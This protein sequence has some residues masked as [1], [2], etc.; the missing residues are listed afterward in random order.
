MA[1]ERYKCTVSFTA[2]N[3]RH[4]PWHIHVDVKV[5]DVLAELIQICTSPSPPNPFAVDFDYFDA[6]HLPERALASGA[7]AAFLQRIVASAPHSYNKKGK[8]AH[9]M[10]VPISENSEGSQIHETI[11]FKH[12]C[13]HSD[14]KLYHA[15]IP[16]HVGTVYWLYFL[17]I[18]MPIHLLIYIL[19]SVQSDLLKISQCHFNAVSEL[20]LEGAIQPVSPETQPPQHKET[21][22]PLRSQQTSGQMSSET[23]QQHH[24]NTSDQ[25]KF[26]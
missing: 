16:M 15:H 2:F 19:H 5:W 6:L 17:S 12:G 14:S 3:L 24:C 21:V 8:I 10:C 20:L 1:R 11:N 23:M 22:S 9:L 25:W 18:A 13:M 7:M 26:R 4:C